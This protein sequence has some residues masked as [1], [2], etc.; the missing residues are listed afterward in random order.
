[1]EGSGGAERGE[2][3]VVVVVVRRR[4]CCVRWL[5]KEVWVVIRLVVRVVSSSTSCLFL[6]I[7]WAGGKGGKGFT[8]TSHSPCHFGYLDLVGSPR[9]ARSHCR[10]RSRLLLSR[11]ERGVR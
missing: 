6:R 7:H 11:D 4:V 2:K 5:V 3:R 1:M 9:P 10:R 8:V